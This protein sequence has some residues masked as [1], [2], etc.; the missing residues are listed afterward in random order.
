MKKWVLGRMREP[1]TYAAIGLGV[2]GAGVIANNFWVVLAGMIVGIGA[3][4]LKEKGLI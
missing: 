2:V 1:S 4:I 3:F